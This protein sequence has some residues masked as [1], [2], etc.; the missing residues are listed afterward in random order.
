[1]AIYVLVLAAM[2][3]LR[4]QATVHWGQLLL[5]GLI[6]AAIIWVTTIVLGKSISR[7]LGVPLVAMNLPVL[8]MITTMCFPLTKG[9]MWIDRVVRRLAGNRADDSAGSELLQSIEDTQREGTL[10]VQSAEILENVVEFTNTEVSQVMTVRSDIEAIEFTNDMQVI[11]AFIGHALHSRIPVFRGSIDNIVGILY[12]KDL[13]KYLGQDASGFR[14][15]PLLRQPIV[16][17]ETKPVRELLSVFQRSEVHLAIVIN[18]YGGTA[19]L[20]TIENVL[21][22]IVGEIRDEHEP[23]VDQEPDFRTIDDTHAEVDGRFRIDELNAKLRLQL[24]EEQ[25]YDTISGLL[26]D[27]FGR[28][29]DAGESIELGGAR[30]TALSATPTSLKRIGIETQLKGGV[31]RPAGVPEPSPSDADGD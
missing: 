23:E 13:I 6:S 11:R 4:T 2:I 21:E 14:L 19:G 1:M 8:R 3:G 15:A 24:S 25:D 31:E 12:L 26:V 5:A 30:F 29:P 7:H 27:K 16:V 18:E 28:V 22:E 20:V 17:P 9:G 10:D